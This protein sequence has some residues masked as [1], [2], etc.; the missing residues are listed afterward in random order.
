MRTGVADLPLHG[1]RAPAWLFQRMTALAREVLRLMVEEFGPAEVLRRLSDPFWFQAFGCLLGFDWHSSGVT[2]TVCGAVA[3]AVKGREQDFGF[4]AAGGK[5]RRSRRTPEQILEA[6]ERS[7][8]DG[9]R[10]V[11]TSRITAKVDSAAVQD[12][13]QV[14]HHMIFWT[15][16]GTWAVVQQGMNPDNRC[17]RRYHWLDR[18]DAPNFDNDPHKAVCC[19]VRHENVLNL[20]AAEN[21]AVRRH[22]LELMRTSPD[23]FRRELNRIAHLEMPRRHWMMLRDLDVRRLQSVQL[24]T[25]ERAPEDFAGLLA[26][27]GTGPSLLRAL[28]LTAELLY[29]N[30]ITWRDPARFSFAHGGKDGTPYPV[31]RDV[32][33]QTIAVLQDLAGRMRVDRSE[34]RRAFR[35]LADFASR[36]ADGPADSGPASCCVRPTDSRLKSRSGPY[37]PL[38]FPSPDSAS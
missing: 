27:P 1:G 34:K 18:L 3:E 24:K 21:A 32:Y 23:A 35:R 20:V 16:D 28:A 6:C 22:T 30:R 17:A 15:L 33:D 19:D 2:T 36:A 8:C 37:Q 38:L 11:M 5:G 12:G 31:N 4:Y 26:T 13:Y 9:E 29:G 25:Y 10:L 7:G 14:Y